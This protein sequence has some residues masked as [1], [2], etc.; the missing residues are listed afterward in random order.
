MLVTVAALAVATGGVTGHAATPGAMR[1]EAGPVRAIVPA[2]CVW[3][4]VWIPRHVRP[5]GVVVRGH[6]SHHKRKVCG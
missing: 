2:D 6:W 1:V 4:R 3:K 5:N